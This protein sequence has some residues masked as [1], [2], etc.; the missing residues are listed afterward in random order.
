MRLA[1]MILDRVS[2]S[3][4]G[5][6]TLRDTSE[7]RVHESQN[8]GLVEHGRVRVRAARPLTL[9]TCCRFDFPRDAPQWCV[10]HAS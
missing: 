4:I 9:V 3:L 1:L 10:L 7:Y 6:L 5:R 8:S 2:G